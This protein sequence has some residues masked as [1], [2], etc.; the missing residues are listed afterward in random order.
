LP[1]YYV[2]LI[3][4]TEAFNPANKDKITSLLAKANA[5]LDVELAKAPNKI[6]TTTK[7][8]IIKPWAVITCRYLK[9]SPLKNGLPGYASSILIIVA[10]AAP[11]QPVH[12]LKKR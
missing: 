12:I 10:N 11:E 4:T 1:N 8:T 6:G 9:E 3:N 2:A 7:K 5:A